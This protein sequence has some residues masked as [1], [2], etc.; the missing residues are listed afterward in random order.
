[1]A[2]SDGRPYK[3]WAEFVGYQSLA[4]HGGAILG[5]RVEDVELVV[6]SHKNSVL[7]GYM[8]I[9]GRHPYVCGC[10]LGGA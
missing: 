1:M 7:S 8:A 10:A 9:L 2:K 5:V 6:R 3:N 4:I